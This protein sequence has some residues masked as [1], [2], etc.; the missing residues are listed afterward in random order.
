MQE[1]RTKGLCFNCDDK[2]SFNHKC[3]TPQ[4]LSLLVDGE[5]PTNASV[6]EVDDPS[7]PCEGN[8]PT[9]VSPDSV[10]P[11]FAPP[12]GQFYMSMAA[13]MGYIMPPNFAHAGY[14]QWPVNNGVSELGQYA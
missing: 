8:L 2:Y 14:G 7:I 10:H 1:R 4:F 12:D 11:Q 5:E 3:K 9:S 13:Y 6:G